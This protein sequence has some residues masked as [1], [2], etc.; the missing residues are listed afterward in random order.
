MSTNAKYINLKTNPSIFNAKP[1]NNV[2]SKNSNSFGNSKNA[3]SEYYETPFSWW[4]AILWATF[5]LGLILVVAG[6]IYTLI[7]KN[8]LDSEPAKKSYKPLSAAMLIIGLILCFL[9]FIISIFTGVRM[10]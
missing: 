10:L 4:S 2:F 6:F 5:A 9:P 7:N 3:N 1:Q 8:T